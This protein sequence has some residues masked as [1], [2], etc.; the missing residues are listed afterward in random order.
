MSFFYLSELV[1]PSRKLGEEYFKP[2]KDLI[3]IPAHPSHFVHKPG[4]RE[5]KGLGKGLVQGQTVTE[6]ESWGENLGHCFPSN[7]APQTPY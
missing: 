1:L 3:K 6:R 7:P 4:L 5:G 2:T